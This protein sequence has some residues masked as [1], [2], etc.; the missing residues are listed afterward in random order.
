MTQS[1]PK[2]LIGMREFRA[3]FQTLS[4]PVTVVNSKGLKPVGTWIPAK[5]DQA[6]LVQ[7]A[8]YPEED[9]S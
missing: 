1:R 5:E 6:R 3:T 9:R 2:K 4:E 8:Q 7:A